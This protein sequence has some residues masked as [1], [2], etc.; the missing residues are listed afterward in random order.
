MKS[1]PSEV[2]YT[3]LKEVQGFFLLVFFFFFNCHNAGK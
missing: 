2:R 1:C 3:W